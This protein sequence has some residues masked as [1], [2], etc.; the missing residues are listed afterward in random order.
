M[1][2]RMRLWK[3]PGMPLGLESSGPKSISFT[4][5]LVSARP[6]RDLRGAWKEFMERKQFCFD[7]KGVSEEGFLE[8]YAS[9]K[10]EV[11]SYGDVVL[12]GAYVNL[13]EFVR[14]GFVSFGHDHAGMPIGYV[15]SAREDSR[16]L[17]VSMRFHGTA[18]AREAW[19]VAAERM[20]AGR[21]VGLSIGYLP[22]KWRYE[23]RDGRRVRLLEALELKEFSLVTMPAARSATATGVKSVMAGDEA[24]LALARDWERVALDVF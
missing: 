13:G 2:P 17:F 14:E 18:L 3:H 15:E 16:G 12:D 11:D 6:I 1:Q 22:V 5:G 23:E 7:V 24:V 9:V 10:N 4:F 20:E 21:T 19:K 8:G